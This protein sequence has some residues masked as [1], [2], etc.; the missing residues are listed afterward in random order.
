METALSELRVFVSST[1]EDLKGHRAVARLVID[2]LRWRPVMMEDFGASSSATVQACRQELESC[3]LVLLIVAFRRG[4]VPSQE[5]GGNGKDSITALELEHARARNIPVLVMAANEDWPR[6]LCDTEPVA[7]GWI[8]QFRANLN[9]PW[10]LFAAEVGQG[11]GDADKR[12]PAFRELC[13]KVLLA[14]KQRLLDATYGAASA[15]T[16]DRHHVDSARES[17]LDA[18]CVAVL[19][20]GLFGNGPLGIHA[21]AQALGE[22]S[23]GPGEGLAT[24]AEFRERQLLTRTRFLKELARIITL[25]SSQAELPA[26]LGMLVDL[27][28][29]PPIVVCTSYDLLLEQAL[30]RHPTRRHVVITHIL[31]SADNAD[32]GKIIALR[33]GEPPVISTADQ[34]KVQADELVIYRPLG[35]P[36]LSE[37][38]DPEREIDTVVIT[39]SDHLT[40]LGRLGNEHMKVPTRLATLLRKQPLLFLGYG[41]DVWQYRLF[42]QVFS[43]I[44]GRKRDAP[45]LAVRRPTSAIEEAS[46]AALNT[47]LIHQD[48]NEFA[49]A[50]IAPAQTA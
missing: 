11:E 27:P 13:R 20:P 47:K 7:M 34:V 6:R 42:M 46:W 40:F 4:Y 23:E 15:G 30:S 5:Q 29:P 17:L 49:R 18:S 41:L 33:P 12:L 19:G 35:S 24:V 48:P 36:L 3:Q 45:T 16:Q 31:R 39:E 38:I 43:V 50:V 22:R 2:N 26:C 10:E 37:H 28:A 32:D 8:N 14:H 9:L 21:L 25:Q 44:G 1:S